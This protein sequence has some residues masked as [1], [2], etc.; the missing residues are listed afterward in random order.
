MFKDYKPLLVLLV[1]VVHSASK[2]FLGFGQGH[3]IRR[4]WLIDISTILACDLGTVSWFYRGKALQ[5]NTTLTLKKGE[6]LHLGCRFVQATQTHHHAFYITKGT[7]PPTKAIGSTT[8][9]DYQK[10]ELTNPGTLVYSDYDGI[11]AGFDSLLVIPTSF[12][13]YGPNHFRYLSI[14]QLVQ[15]DAGTYHCS[16][17][18]YNAVTAPAVSTAADTA[19][20]AAPVKSENRKARDVRS[21]RNRRSF[22]YTDASADGSIA[23]SG[24]LTIVV[25]GVLGQSLASSARGQSQPTKFLTYSAMMLSANKLL[26]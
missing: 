3:W 19:V 11:Q 25:K 7:L 2:I 22:A 16:V 17:Y 18:E 24:G 1:F 6:P 4:E 23:T 26:F 14:G 12:G 21:G 8:S 5:S 13:T 15:A 20:E 10:V 9:A